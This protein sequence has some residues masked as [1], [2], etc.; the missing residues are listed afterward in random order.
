M[1]GFFKKLFE[2]CFDK[3]ILDYVSEYFQGLIYVF[4]SYIYI[5]I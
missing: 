2:L 3:Y 5:Y 1:T 4:Q